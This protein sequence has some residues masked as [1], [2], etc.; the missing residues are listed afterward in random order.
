MANKAIFLDRDNTLIEDPGYISHPDQ[1][2]LLDGVAE[3]L[4]ELRQMG[5]KLVVASNQSGVAR[6][7]VTEQMLAE[8]HE[9][10]QE[11]LGRQGAALDK[12]YYCPDHPDGAI[13]R[14]RKESSWR[15]PAPGML[16]AAAEDLDIDLTDSWLVGDSARDIDAGKA[17]GCKTILIENPL[18][19]RTF[20]PGATSPDYTA[21]NMKEVVNIIKK[22]DRDRHKMEIEST[23]P[24]DDPEIEPLIAAATDRPVENAQLDQSKT[25]EQLLVDIL[26]QLRRN[27]RAEMFTE[28]SV[29]R[30]IAGIV[31]VIVLFCLLIS[32]WL[33]MSPARPSD[34]LMISLGFALV[35]QVMALTFFIMQRQK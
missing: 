5:Y 20:E 1:V 29:T 32:V 10:L 27:Q 7:I 25:A 4:V 8:I 22:R 23:A 19:S 28:F 18:H 24:A 21:V 12:I 3:T 30:L 17:A 2:K 33:L 16:L 34:A 11:L 13:P 9:R 35:F 6:G 15:K 14:Y 26:E 31:Q